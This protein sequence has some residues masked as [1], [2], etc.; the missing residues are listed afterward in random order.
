MKS[1]VVGYKAASGDRD[2]L[3]Q[4]VCSHAVRANRK[5]LF[6]DTEGTNKVKWKIR[7]AVFWCECLMRHH[8]AGEDKQLA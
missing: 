7:F 3:V 6:R 1:G 4:A 8:H 2:I 5:M